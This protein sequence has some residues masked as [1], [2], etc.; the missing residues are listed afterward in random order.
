M[1]EAQGQA[2]TSS[3]PEAGAFVRAEPATCDDVAGNT[4]FCAGREEAPQR[5]LSFRLVND[6]SILMLSWSCS[7]PSSTIPR[8][9]R[10]DP[11]CAATCHLTLGHDAS[12]SAGCEVME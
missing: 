6:A 2:R 1:T 10:A 8:G 3:M 5:L 9:T 7:G 4:A 11:R 12:I